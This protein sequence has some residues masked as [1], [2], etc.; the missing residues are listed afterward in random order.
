MPAIRVLIVDDSVVV[1][2]LLTEVLSNEVDIE[3]AGNAADGTKGLNKIALLQPD[4]VTL[5]IE[6][7]G[8]TGLETVV[9]IRKLYPK[10]PVIM[11]STLTERGGSLTLEALALGASDYVTKPSNTGSLEQTRARIREELVPKVRELCKKRTTLG[12]V[13]ANRATARGASAYFPQMEKA[14]KLQAPLRQKGT[15]G[16]VLA[17]ARTAGRACGACIRVQAEHAFRCGYRH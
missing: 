6:M 8:I 2:R 13:D 10:L 4:M 7:P 11:F 5:D 9:E 12:I 17:H 3:V 1:R 16:S 15:K 14:P